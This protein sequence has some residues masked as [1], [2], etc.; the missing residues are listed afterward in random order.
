MK[1]KTIF[2]LILIIVVVIASVIIIG[3]SQQN[4]TIA[5]KRITETVTG[6]YE[7]LTS[8]VDRLDKYEKE[9]EIYIADAGDVELD[10]SIQE[11]KLYVFRIASAENDSTIADAVDDKDILNFLESTEIE[12]ISIQKNIFAFE[13][14]ALSQDS[15]DY[16][17]CGFYYSLNSK[18]QI[19]LF[20]DNCELKKNYDGWY[21]EFD[22][23]VS[24]YYTE[25][26]TDS[27]YYYEGVFCP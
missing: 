23:G 7:L 25:K 10:S 12:K 1:K 13:A 9:D 11:G 4:D 20:D 5:D 21:I 19:V 24:S 26:I 15:G 17:F 3:L 27:F 8:I 18:P 14:D 2:I 16:G 6:N 22:D